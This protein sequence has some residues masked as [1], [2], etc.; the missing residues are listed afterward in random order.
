MVFIVDTTSFIE[1]YFDDWLACLYNVSVSKETAGQLVTLL[2]NHHHMLC[3]TAN[4]DHLFWFIKPKF[5]AIVGV[6]NYGL[7]EK[8]IMFL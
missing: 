4:D 3:A 8:L 7:V 6:I 2:N 1:V 5:L